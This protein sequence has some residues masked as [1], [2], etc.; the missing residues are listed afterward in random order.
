MWEC[1][2]GF[3]STL[4]EGADH[5]MR[6]AIAR[7]FKE[8]SGYEPDFIFSGWGAALR[9]SE[10]AVVDDRLPDPEAIVSECHVIIDEALDAMNRAKEVIDDA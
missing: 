3:V 5:P 2:V 1:K 9:E 4:P 10:R 8:I 7:A 6:Q